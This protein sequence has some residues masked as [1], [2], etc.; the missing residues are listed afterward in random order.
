M[1]T[2]RTVLRCAISPVVMCFVVCSYAQSQPVV[3]NPNS[4]PSER[5]SNAVVLLSPQQSILYVGD[6]TN[7][8]LALQKQSAGVR[9][10][11]I[12]GEQAARSYERY[13]K[14]FEHPIPEHYASGL[15]VKK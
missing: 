7:A 12:D 8:M 4:A 11:A 9:S 10:R 3:A 14:S 15:E 2:I 5:P 1:K 13:L 6:Q